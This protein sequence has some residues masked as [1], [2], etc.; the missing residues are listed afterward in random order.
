[1]AA[2]YNEIN[3]FCVEVLRARIADGDLPD[4][5]VDDR[6]IRDV[7]P[8]DLAGFSQC[9]FFAGIGLWPFA[10]RLVGWPDDRELWT[11]SAPCQPFSCAGKG[12]GDADPRHLWP[13]FFRL[14]RAHRPTV[15]MGEQVEAAVGKGW[16]DRVQSDL[17]REGYASR[18]IV[19]PACAVNAPHRRNRLWFVADRGRERCAEARTGV[20]SAGKVEWPR[21]NSEIDGRRCEQ[22]PMANGGRVDGGEGRS[23]GSADS[24]SRLSNGARGDAVPDG[25]SKPERKPQ[26]PLGTVAWQG[27]GGHAGGRFGGHA[28]SGDGNAWSDATPLACADGRVRRIKPG[29]RLLVDGRPIDV[30][31][32]LTALGNGIVPQIAA[33]VIAAYLECDD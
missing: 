24:G 19:V 8:G 6:S 18:G 23:R 31:D 20:D 1:M 13:D 33:E 3:Q 30:A 25:G 10:A 2:Y 11:G 4:G 9:H 14:I 17:A 26:H 21:S 22:S 32:A 12:K 29:V 7:E 16:F 15:L 28:Q 5:I 27:A